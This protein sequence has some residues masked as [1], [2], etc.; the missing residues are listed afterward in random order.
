MDKKYILFDLDGT[1]TDPKT[2]ITRS[3]AYALSRFG[4]KVADTDTLV[5]FN[6]PPLISSFMDRYGFSRE[7]AE[8]AVEAYR[9]YF[10]TREYLKTR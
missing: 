8:K 1:L 2:G 6:G 10:R 9:E 7:K 4:I 5:P 3:V